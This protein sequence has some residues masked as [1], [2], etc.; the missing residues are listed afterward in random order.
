MTVEAASNNARLERYSHMVVEGRDKR[1]RIFSLQEQKES[2]SDKFSLGKRIKKHTTQREHAR[3]DSPESTAPH[4]LPFFFDPHTQDVLGLPHRQHASDDAVGLVKLV[5]DEREEKRLEKER[6]DRMCEAKGEFAAAADGIG[7]GRG[8][9]QSWQSRSGEVR[10]QLKSV[11]SK[12]DD[13]LSHLLPDTRPS[14]AGEEN[15]DVGDRRELVWRDKVRIEVEE[16]FNLAKV[17]CC[18]QMR[19]GAGRRNRVE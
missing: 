17:S 15:E 1:L 5:A 12:L 19:D 11:L 16:G 3:A 13:S 9:T 8:I 6:G 10:R 7:A 18:I 14:D 4:S 2:I